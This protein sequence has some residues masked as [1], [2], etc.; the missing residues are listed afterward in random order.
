VLPPAASVAILRPVIAPLRFRLF[1]V[2]AAAQAAHLDLGAS[3]MVGDRWRD[4]AAGQRAGC[5]SIFIDYNY[6]EPQPHAPYLRAQ[7]LHEAADLI[8]CQQ[9]LVAH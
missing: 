9:H 1:P 8:L 2:V 3:F 4:V 6:A 5:Q 7:S